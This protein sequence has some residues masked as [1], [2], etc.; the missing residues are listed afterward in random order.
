MHYFQGSREHRPPL[1]GG[2]IVGNQMWR[3]NYNDFF[4]ISTLVLL[5]PDLSIFENTVDP[6]QLAS[7]EAI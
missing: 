7:D 3:L 2:L 6:D 5:N 4:S 1:G